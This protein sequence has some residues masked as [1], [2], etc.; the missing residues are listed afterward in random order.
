[1][2]VT[3]TIWLLGN[4]I[5]ASLVLSNGWCP[6]HEKENERGNAVRK[7]IV[8][9]ALCGNSEKDSSWQLVSFFESP[10]FLKTVVLY[11]N[12]SDYCPW[13]LGHDLHKTSLRCFTDTC[14]AFLYPYVCVDFLS[15]LSSLPHLCCLLVCQTRTSGMILSVQCSFITRGLALY[16]G[17]QDVTSVAISAL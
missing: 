16:F 17:N 7:W 12:L 14:E 1:M 6:L 8:W 11:L 2:I 4:G 3:K 13:L 5:F 9:R 15:W 10:L